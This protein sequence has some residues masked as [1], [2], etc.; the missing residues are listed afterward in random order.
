MNRCESCGAIV[1][2]DLSVCGAGPNLICQGRDHIPGCGEALTA[3]ER[4]WYGSTCEHCEQTWALAIEAWRKG[5]PDP[6]LD[7]MFGVEGTTRT[8]H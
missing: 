7:R 1:E 6:D 8:R 3:E 2:G 5:A 4:H